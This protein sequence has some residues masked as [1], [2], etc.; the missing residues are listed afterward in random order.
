MAG[1]VQ[2]LQ[3]ELHVRKF[4]K[5][6]MPSRNDQ[7]WCSF[8]GISS[9]CLEETTVS[10]GMEIFVGTYMRR[11]LSPC[12]ISPRIENSGQMKPVCENKLNLSFS[13]M[14]SQDKSKSIFGSPCFRLISNLFIY[15]RRAENSANYEVQ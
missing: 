15:L 14:G 6:F 12:E 11:W 3:R 9:K 4:G 1:E 2:T 7:N 8:R 5:V 13:N 10:L